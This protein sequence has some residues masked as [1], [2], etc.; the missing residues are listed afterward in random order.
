MYLFT[1]VSTRSSAAM[2]WVLVVSQLASW[3][4]TNFLCTPGTGLCCGE[5]QKREKYPNSTTILPNLDENKKRNLLH[6]F[7]FFFASDPLLNFSQG[8]PHQSFV[9]GLLPG[10]LNRF[11]DI[12]LL[13]KITIR[14]VT[15]TNHHVDIGRSPNWEE[16][17]VPQVLLW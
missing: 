16:T 9:Q 1:K 4:D 8:L 3:P 15:P 11:L 6:N 13:P 7:F 17:V 12:S 2:D 10:G 5:G 14:G